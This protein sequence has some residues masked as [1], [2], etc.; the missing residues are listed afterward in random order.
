MYLSVLDSNTR[1][2][3]WKDTHPPNMKMLFIPPE[4]IQVS[5]RIKLACHIASAKELPKGK[6]F[7]VVHQRKPIEI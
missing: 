3:S 1:I 4:N 6:A 5:W 7:E 2:Y